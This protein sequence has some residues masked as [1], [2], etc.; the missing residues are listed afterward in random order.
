MKVA[1]LIVALGLLAPVAA[2]PYSWAPPPPAPYL[3]PSDTVRSGTVRGAFLQGGLVDVRYGQVC[4]DRGGTSE[5][6][7]VAEDTSWTL[8]GELV[9]PEGLLAL[10]PRGLAVAARFD[11]QTG[12]LGW[13][14]AFTPGP[15]PDE[16]FACRL[17]S[18]RGVAFQQG[19]TLN[20]AIS[21]QTARSLSLRTPTLF[22]PGVVH[23]LPLQPQPGGGYRVALLIRAGWDGRRLPL[24]VRSQGRVLR[25]P[26]VDISTSAP[27]LRDVGPQVV[28]V[29]E[30][31]VPGWVDV[32]SASSL[33][34]P[35]TARWRSSPGLQIG[36]TQ[37]RVDRCLFEVRALHP[38]EHWVEFEIADAL[39]RKATRR[40][41]VRALP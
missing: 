3:A 11:P 34:A 1:T 20:L 19:E 36:R 9:T 25:G 14:D 8:D 37:P 2:A 23:D 17:S 33:L 35:G 38:G 5:V 29:S 22:V 4:I 28:S 26:T 40:W 27:E 16:R 31:S 30:G 24:F 6:L 7:E 13:L 21:S 18:P 41:T 39:G 10:V 32:A 15:G 12:R